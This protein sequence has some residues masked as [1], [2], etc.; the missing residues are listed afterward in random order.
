MGRQPSKKWFLSQ[1]GDNNVSNR[2]NCT[3]TP[4]PVAVDDTGRSQKRRAIYCPSDDTVVRSLGH[5]SDVPNEVS[6]SKPTKILEEDSSHVLLSWGGLL[7]FQAEN[8]CCRECL[9]PISIA[10]F[11]KVQVQ[12]ATSMNYFCL[13]KRVCKLEAVTTKSAVLQST[14]FAT[15]RLATD[16]AINLKMVLVLQ[17]LGHGGAASCVFGGMLSIVPQALRNCGRPWRRG[18]ANP[19]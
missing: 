11:E 2:R 3:D 7:N 6:P 1:L 12:F 9:E 15:Q 13:C 4:V 10:R 17:Q 16:Y 18:L 19:R 14:S 8:F 5:D